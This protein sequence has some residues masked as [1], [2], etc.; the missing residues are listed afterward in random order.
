M[1]TIIKCV[2]SETR[3][4]TLHGKIML[5]LEY[6]PSWPV[7]GAINILPGFMPWNLQIVNVIYRDMQACDN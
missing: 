5:G 1:L 7:G 4:F 6:I 2:T 3:N